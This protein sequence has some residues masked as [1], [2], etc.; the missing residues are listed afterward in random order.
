MSDKKMVL[1]L[2][3]I[4]IVFLGLFIVNSM[5]ISHYECYYHAVERV[6]DK[7]AEQYPSFMDTV[8]ETDEYCDYCEIKKGL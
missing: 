2:G 4:A 6:L 7:T 8:G 5:R 1:V 3:C